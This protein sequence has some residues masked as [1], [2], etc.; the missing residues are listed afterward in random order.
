MRQ[1]AS[2]EEVKKSLLARCEQQL[3]FTSR[4]TSGLKDTTCSRQIVE[5]MGESSYS[6]SSNDQR[7]MKKSE[8]E[9]LRSWKREH[10]RKDRKRKRID[11]LKKKHEHEKKILNYLQSF[12]AG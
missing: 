10:G 3:K 12:L 7:N 9:E 4:F 11:N 5:R 2:G 1:R 8:L 6:S